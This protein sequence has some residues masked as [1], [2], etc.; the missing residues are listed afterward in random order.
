MALSTLNCTDRGFRVSWFRLHPKQKTGDV[1]TFHQNL[2]NGEDRGDGDDIDHQIL[3][4]DAGIPPHHI[5]SDDSVDQKVQD[6]EWITGFAGITQVR[7]IL[8][9][10]R[11]VCPS[12]INAIIQHQRPR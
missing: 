6:I 1:C 5:V 7:A 4:G 10:F 8:L 12:P 3:Y 11:Y 9:L 2:V